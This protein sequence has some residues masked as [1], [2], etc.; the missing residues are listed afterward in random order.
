MCW[1]SRDFEA[2]RSIS[3][4][5]LHSA[6]LL[7]RSFDW[8]ARGLPGIQSAQ[9]R[10]RVIETFLF[11]CEHR[12]G[13]RVFLRSSTVSDDHLVAWQLFEFRRDLARGNRNGARDVAGLVI[14]F[15][16]SIN[17][18]H[19]L[20]VPELMQVFGGN[21][22]R[23]VGWVLRLRALHRRARSLWEDGFL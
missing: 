13:A 20:L 1:E 8:I 21:S 6:F 9:Q 16:A 4:N 3:R 11:E 7:R 17:D 22:P 12:T 19:V 23:F 10:R 5:V 2:H 15:A 14:G 18:Q